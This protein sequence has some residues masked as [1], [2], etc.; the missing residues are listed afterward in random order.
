MFLFQFE[1]SIFLILNALFLTINASFAER[2]FSEIFFLDT[3]QA[4]KLFLTFSC[5]LLVFHA[6]KI[7]NIQK[8]LDIIL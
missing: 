8:I 7:S 4:S 2:L 5:S 3:R 6:R 1:N